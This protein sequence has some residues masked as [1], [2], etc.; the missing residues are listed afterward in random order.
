MSDDSDIEQSSSDINVAS[1]LSH[2]TLDMSVS[3]LSFATTLVNAHPDSHLAS[4]E[5][6]SLVHL[7]E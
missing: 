7:A 2:A 4:E 6:G 5:V 1:W 3:F